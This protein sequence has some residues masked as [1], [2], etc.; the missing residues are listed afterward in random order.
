MGEYSQIEIA[1]AEVVLMKVLVVC[2]KPEI[3]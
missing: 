3:V 1:I 2:L